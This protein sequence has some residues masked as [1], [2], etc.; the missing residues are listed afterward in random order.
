[1][2]G[3]KRSKWSKRSKWGDPQCLGTTATERTVFWRRKS[4][5]V[6]D[7]PNARYGLKLGGF[8]LLTP[9]SNVEP[10]SDSRADSSSCSGLQAEAAEAGPREQAKSAL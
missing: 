4:N 5:D 2:F 7:F 10:S 1:M 8:M 9:V 6:H 3:V